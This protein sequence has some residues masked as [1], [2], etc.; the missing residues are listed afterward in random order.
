MDENKVN[1]ESEIPAR[2]GKV[3]L[4]V[5]IAAVA[6]LVSLAVGL[7]IFFA[8]KSDVSSP[9]RE[10]FYFDGFEYSY[11]TEDSLTITAYKGNDSDVYVPS[12]IA[13][14]AVVEIASEAFLGNEDIKSIS[15][16]MFLTEISDR[17]FVGCAEIKK[18]T[19]PDSLKKI[20]DYAKLP[21]SLG[22]IYLGKT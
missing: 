6:V 1:K 12:T 18:V 13:G 14:I 5:I 11:K 20:G 8:I 10:V 9:Q 21:D 4:I 22:D 7:I 17:A 16:G 3:R 19:F 15:F 2:N